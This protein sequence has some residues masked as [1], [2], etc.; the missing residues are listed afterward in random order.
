MRVLATL[1]LFLF[2]VSWS[3]EQ[4]PI[5]DD[6][7]EA[8]DSAIA[9]DSGETGSVD[10]VSDEALP[11][12]N[13]TAEVAPIASAG[14]S[15]AP[16]QAPIATT[17]AAS[18]AEPSEV[19]IEAELNVKKTQEQLPTPT[20]P[21][22]TKP[23]PPAPSTRVLPASPS[24]PTPASQ[25]E[26]IKAPDPLDEAEDTELINIDT[27]D[28]SE[29][30]GNWFLKR[31]WWE[32]SERVYERLRHILDEIFDVRMVFFNQ[33]AEQDRKTFN[34]FYKEAGLGQAEIQDI[35]QDLTVLAEHDNPEDDSEEDRKIKQQIRD[36]QESIT[37]LIAEIDKVTE[38]DSALNAALATLRQQLDV[39]RSNERQAWESFKSI[40]RVLSDKKA[41]EYYYAMKSYKTNVLEISEYLQNS[42]AQYYQQISD[43]AH[44]QVKK[45]I[46]MIQTL[47]SKGID[48]KA[49]AA[50]FDNGKACKR[51]ADQKIELQDE[52]EMAQGSWISHI[53]SIIR[54]PFAWIGSFFGYGASEEE[55]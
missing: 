22:T 28:L 37:A 21:A 33:R 47:K 52:D 38:Y 39:A 51:I 41:A 27:I 5:T 54:S 12:D 44:A 42:F 45:V 46:S 14:S 23:Q 13:A 29:P 1:F 10:D 30:K 31:Q 6:V 2:V 18:A 25:P 26:K 8:P 11:R 48:L 9:G 55:V 19:S 15:S 53:W 32:K 17:P 3:S 24:V 50:H 34:L 20:P 4:P 40:A 36:E 16:E 7:A 49:H 35:L 43:L